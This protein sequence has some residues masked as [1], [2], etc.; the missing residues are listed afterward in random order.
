MSEYIVY[1]HDE[2][3]DTVFF[4]KSCDAEYVRESLINHD[5]YNSSIQVIKQGAMLEELEYLKTATILNSEYLTKQAID[6]GV[7]CEQSQNFFWGY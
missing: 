7:Y 2:E 3:I 1:D 5:G 4:D 6:I